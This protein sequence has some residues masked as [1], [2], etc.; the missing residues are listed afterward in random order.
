[1][2]FFGT[3][4]PIISRPVVP[5]LILISVSSRKSAIASSTMYGLPAFSAIDL[6]LDQAEARRAVDERRAEDRHVMLVGELDEA[7][8]LLAVLDEILAHLA[9]EGAARIGLGLE[10]L[11]DL[12]DRVVDVLELLPRRCRCRRCGRCRASAACRRRAF[13]APDSACGQGPR[14]NPCRRSSRRWRRCRRPCC[15]APARHRGPCSRRREVEPAITRKIV[16]SLSA[17]IWL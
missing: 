10:R 8:V 7:V 3:P 6:V 15:C 16:Q 5:A 17:S 9:D 4:P 1:M 12:E 13:R 14:R 11:G 2:K